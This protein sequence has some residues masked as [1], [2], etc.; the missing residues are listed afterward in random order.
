M[1]IILSCEKEHDELQESNF[2]EKIVLNKENPKLHDFAKLIAKS[3]EDEKGRL[4]IKNEALKEFDGDFDIL[5]SKFKNKKLD[6]SSLKATSFRTYENYLKRFYEFNNDIKS[7]DDYELFLNSLI[8]KYPLLQ[9]SIPEI[10]EGST[11]KWETTNYIPLVAILPDNYNEETTKVI[12]AYDINGNVTYLNINKIPE[13]PVLVIGQNERLVAI[14]KEDVNLKNNKKIIQDP[15]LQFYYETNN[16]EY[17]IPI[18]C[19][20]GGSTGGGG[21][22]DPPTYDRDNNNNKDQLYKARFTSKTAFRQVEPWPKGRPEFKVIITYIEKIG[23]NYETKT[24]TKI[25]SKSDWITR[26]VLWT[27]LKTKHI[28]LPIITWDKEKIGN[29]MKYTWI[30]QDN[31][32]STTELNIAASTDFGEDE[33]IPVNGSIKVTIGTDDTEAGEAIV[34]YKDNTTGD[35]TEYNTGIMRFWVNQL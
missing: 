14:K 10:Y 23:S 3:M 26:Y 22:D 18:D 33:D 5:F 15:C 16:Y 7:E 25:L 24:I 29:S 19:G 4:F 17:Y 34:E 6:N 28:N 13:K 12:S 32:N 8:E 20:G 21:S 27:D 1:L 11:E 35:G 30:E 2:K 9:I 31:S